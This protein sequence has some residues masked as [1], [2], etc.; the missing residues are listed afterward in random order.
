MKNM[1]CCCFFFLGGGGG[2]GLL[3]TLKNKMAMEN[4]GRLNTAMFVGEGNKI[5]S[6]R[7]NGWDM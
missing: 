4:P 2:G 6:W 5:E 3:P 7:L 1:S